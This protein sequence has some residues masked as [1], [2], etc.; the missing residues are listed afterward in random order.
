MNQCKNCYYDEYC[1]I[2]NY[3][4]IREC[5]YTNIPTCVVMNS[6]KINDILN[7]YGDTIFCKDREVRI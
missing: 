6:H 4:Y 7:K 5:H 2:D 3:C 1:E